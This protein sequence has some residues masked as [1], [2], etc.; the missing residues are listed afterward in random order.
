M[1]SMSVGSV[2]SVNSDS[3]KKEREKTVEDGFVSG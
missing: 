2:K 1:W 3:K